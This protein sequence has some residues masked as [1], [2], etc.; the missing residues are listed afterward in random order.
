M[1]KDNIKKG[2]ERKKGRKERK[3]GMEKGAGLL[4]DILIHRETGLS[5]CFTDAVRNIVPRTNST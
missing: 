4:E 5:I 2:R 3:E 1:L